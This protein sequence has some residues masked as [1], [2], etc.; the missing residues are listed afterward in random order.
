M[1]TRARPRPRSRATLLSDPELAADIGARVRAARL[2]LGIT[3]DQLSGLV[4]IARVNVC[5]LEAGGRG[6]VPVLAILRRLARALD[7]S[8]RELVPPE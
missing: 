1:P 3:Q 6:R 4:G 5:R 2:A 8:L 7:V